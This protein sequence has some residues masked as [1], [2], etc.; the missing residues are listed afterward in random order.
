MCPNSSCARAPFPTLIY[1]IKE[2]PEPVEKD[3]D[4]KAQKNDLAHLYPP[5]ESIDYRSGPMRSSRLKEL[6]HQRHL[7][8]R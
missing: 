4:Y 8:R 2:A 7:D 5:V 3:K 1:R 6:E